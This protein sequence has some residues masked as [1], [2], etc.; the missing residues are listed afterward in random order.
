MSGFCVL[1]A[2]AIGGCEPSATD[3]E[4][5]ATQEVEIPTAP[6]RAKVTTIADLRKALGANDNAQFFKRSGEIYRAQ[7]GQSGVTDLEPLRGVPLTELDLYNLPITDISPL[8][9]MQLRILYLEGTHVSDISVLKGM[10][11]EEL[12]LQDTNVSDLSP[13]EGMPL[14]MLNL[15]GC[16]IDS[17][18]NVSEFPLNTLW[19]P[20]TQVSDLTPLAASNL[21]SL[22]I[23]DTPVESLLPIAGMLSLKRLNMAKCAVTDLRPLKGLALTRLVFTPS[24]ITHGIDLV[25][26]MDSLEEIGPSFEQRLRPDEYWRLYDAGEFSE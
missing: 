5:A 2:L 14:R 4:S 6:A 17:I 23:E 3:S 8:E 11:L 9:G 15:K 7:L 22:D 21:E 18:E 16:P 10:P 1:L 25:R 13:L 26:A 19:I 20:S 12:Y 24:R